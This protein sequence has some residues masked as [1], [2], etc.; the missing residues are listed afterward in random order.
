MANTCK[1]LLQFFP[2]PSFF[3]NLLFCHACRKPFLL[4][5]FKF[6]QSFYA[7][8]NGF[9][10]GEHATH[11]SFSNIVLTTS[12]GVLLQAFPSLLLGGNE[13]NAFP[14]RDSSCNQIGGILQK[15]SGLFEIN[16]MNTVSS[17]EDVIP[18]L[19]VPSAFLVTEVNSGFQHF[20]HGRYFHL[21]VLSVIHRSV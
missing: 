14:G 2:L 5:F 3:K 20:L 1:I 8:G 4:S 13:K 15:S 16:D 17:H 12:D 18:H 6:N 19:R 9:E 7:F 21:I 11:P 10:I